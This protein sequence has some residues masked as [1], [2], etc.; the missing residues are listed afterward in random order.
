MLSARS[1]RVKSLDLHPTEPWVLVSLYNGAAHI[2]NFTT[3]V[4]A[5]R[6]RPLG[7]GRLT[8]MCALRQTLVKQFEVSEVPVRV[9]K[10][11][12]RKSWVIS[13]ADDMQIR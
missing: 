1:D 8:G 9:A 12:P 10:F 5:H 11:V 7:T 13:G 6:R 2:W 3:T 4:R